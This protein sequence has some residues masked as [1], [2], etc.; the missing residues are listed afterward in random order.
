M[1]CPTNS[2][3]PHEHA[4][5]HC[6]GDSVNQQ[7]SAAVSCMLIGQDAGNLC[8]HL[9]F[10]DS[11][12]QM[13]AALL[14]AANTWIQAERVCFERSTDSTALLIL[15]ACWLLLLWFLFLFG[16]EQTELPSK[17]QGKIKRIDMLKAK[18]MLDD[19]NPRWFWKYVEGASFF[20]NQIVS[21]QIFF[22][23]CML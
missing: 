18:W 2:S 10:V 16:M 20:F 6:R 11:C 1:S 19:F 14:S 21:T 23:Y 17:L 8:G 5:T 15:S 12:L 4:H 9:Y 22:L 13:N 7:V 3:G